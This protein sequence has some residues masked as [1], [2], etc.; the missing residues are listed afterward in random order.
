VF[1]WFLPICYTAASLISLS[2]GQKATTVG[3]H[4]PEDSLRTVS[5]PPPLTAHTVEYQDPMSI[6]IAPSF[7]INLE[8]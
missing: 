5:I 4:L 1:L 6:P 3:E 8:S 7:S 2:A